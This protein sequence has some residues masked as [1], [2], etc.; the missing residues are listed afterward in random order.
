MKYDLVSTRVEYVLQV[1]VPDS[2][3]SLLKSSKCKSVEEFSVLYINDA[4]RVTDY[5]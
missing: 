5:V 4:F 3:R 2:L 1:S